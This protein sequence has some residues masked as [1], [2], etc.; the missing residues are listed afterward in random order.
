[1][2]MLRAG[3]VAAL[4]AWTAIDATAALAAP[5]LGD[6]SFDPHRDP[7]SS[8]VDVV[9][10][11]Q[12]D[13]G[14][15]QV[16]RYRPGS[17]VSAAYH[18]GDGTWSVH[19]R[20]L[21]GTRDLARLV[22]DDR[23]RQ[24]R[25]WYFL[26]FDRYPPRLTESRALSIAEHDRA[27]RRAARRFG[28][29]ARLRA[30]ADYLA[31]DGYWEVDFWR[32]DRP[33]LRVDVQDDTADVSG[34]WTG[35][36][37]AWKMARGARDAFGGD[38]NLWYVWWPLFTAFALVM[39]WPARLRSWYSA[40]VLAL[41]SFGVS[42]EFFNRGMIAWS[43]P[44][45]VPP[46]AYLFVRMA[47]IFVRGAPAAPAG[48][49]AR[50]GQG[51]RIARHLRPWPPTWLLVVLAVFAAGTR[52]GVD[53]Y[54]SNVIDVGYA[55]VTGAREIVEHRTPYGNMPSDNGNGDTYGPLNYIA[56]VPAVMVWN[57]PAD[58]DWGT[59][60]PAAY[61][62]SIAADL[63]CVLALVLVGWR[64]MSRRAAA[65]LACGWLTYPYT[66]FALSSN[67]ND[68]LV[69][70]LLLLA[71]AALP[72]AW[73]RGGLVAV[74]AGVKFLPLLALPVLAH[75]GMRVRGRQ[76]MLA[77]A[78]ATV[79]LLACATFVASY[80]DGWKRF[81]DATWRFQYGRESPFSVWGLYGWRRAQ[82]VAQVML[83]VALAAAVLWPR[84]RDFRQVAAG[85]AAALI[86]GQLVLQHWFYLYIPW[87]AGLVLIVLVAQR[88]TR[89]GTLR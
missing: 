85:M 74:A 33:V 40:D 82:Q 87:F 84:V 39:A 64:W 56:Y 80:D 38:I 71:F 75:A 43:V 61:A 83:L 67:V 24:L 68:Q 69:G 86:G 15:Q 35:H 14:V 12:F 41:L 11:A 47:W 48:G 79:V 53:L 30:D 81:L 18:P 59:S 10:V 65:L 25:G 78:A 63:A 32:G 13:K 8:R 1:M 60:L 23:S 76:A 5:G 77:A 28:G 7:V 62:V 42:H 51:R 34:I 73:L 3:V 37:I 54:G 20:E 89:A 49:P 22:V 4:L 58:F 46:L 2:S 29:I 21:G 66:A 50:L 6:R 70:A 16:L 31:D 52:I 88:E 36:Q 17:V 27:V 26:P 72:R 19:V 55:G 57:E 9:A 44:L 45:A